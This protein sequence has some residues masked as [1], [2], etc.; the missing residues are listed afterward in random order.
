MRKIKARNITATAANPAAT[1]NFIS[2]VAPTSTNSRISAA[3]HN[4]EYLGDMRF[5]RTG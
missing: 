2:T 3:T 5:A 4:F 1:A